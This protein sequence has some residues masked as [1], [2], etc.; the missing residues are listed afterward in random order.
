MKRKDFL[1]AFGIAGTAFTLSPVLA[2]AASVVQ[3]V[4]KDVRNITLRGKV[5]AAGKGIAGVA[6]TD[7]LNVTVTDKNGNYELLSISSASFVYISIPSGYAFNQEKGIP[8][9]YEPVVTDA[10]NFKADFALEKLDV[11]DKQHYFVVWA[12]T[13]MI[14]QDD[15]AQLKAQSVP[16]LKQLVAS[17]PKNSLFHGIG[18]GDLV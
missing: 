5:H 12:D 8:R 15:V 16:D 17:Y 6:V 3:P 13:Q 10:A 18:C 1:K 11:D 4:G 14:S 7:G 9:F 2:D